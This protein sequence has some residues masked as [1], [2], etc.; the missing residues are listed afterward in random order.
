[1][2]RRFV[3]A[4][5]ARLRPALATVSVVLAAAGLLLPA[6][7]V[8]AASADPSGPGTGALAECGTPRLAPALRPARG[9]VRGLSPRQRD[10]AA[11]TLR[12]AADAGLPARGQAIVLMTRSSA[13]RVDALRLGRTKVPSVA[14]QARALRR[15]DG[16]ETLPP[17][18]VAHRLLGTPDPYAFEGQ[19][20][21]TLTTLSKA[22]GRPVAGVQAAIEPGARA[23]RQC[24]PKR[25][26]SY[27]V[28]V[29]SGYDL[30][31]ML[32]PAQPAGSGQGG[33]G[34]AGSGQGG[35]GRGSSAKKRSTKDANPRGSDAGEGAEQ[36]SLLL[37]A[38]CGVPVRAVSAGRV[39]IDRS[40]RTSGP[41][42]ITVEQGE[43]RS[44]YRHVTQPLVRYGQ[45]V[46]AGEQ[47]ATV[48]DLGYID[49][50]ALGFGLRIGKAM[51]RDHE[52][53]RWLAPAEAKDKGP[54][55]PSKTRKSKDRE[56]GD[57]GAT[58]SFRITTFNVLGAHLTGRGGDRPRYGAGSA[59][60]AAAMGRLNNSGSSIAV[61][62]EF[63][64]PQAAVVSAAPGWQLHRATGNSRFRS[65]NYSGN[66][67][68]WRTDTW[69]LVETSEFTVPWK[70]RLHM[71]V[72]YLRHVQTGA[73]VAVIGV[74]NPASTK[75]QGDQSR[76]RGV[77]RAVEKQAVAQILSQSEMPV[78]L[79]GDMN[80]RGKAIC[81]FAGAGL[82]TWKSGGGRCGSW[83]YGGV[84]HVFAAGDV[85][86]TGLTVDRSTLGRVSDH[87]MVTA[88]V[89]IN[90]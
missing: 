32:T 77:A 6:P 84:D 8:P 1:M 82:A 87:P 45:R 19:W 80:E 66:A 83:G 42:S 59:R 86:Y 38:P 68:A 70:V 52:V 49:R 73:M 17:E 57:T 5:A 85:A 64:S 89:T 30:L 79:G 7:A 36:P 26:R 29:G 22:T 67:V 63:E 21:R 71:P 76:A 2:T 58:T 27:P 62:Q 3:L 55:T 33:S 23:G 14:R 88:S 47:L 10:L 43:L 74:H 54:V 15:L 11:T 51:L 50:C 24:A 46:E 20:S 16:W 25:G 53:A 35:S 37:G 75:R 18:L 65:G 34:Q 81:D 60:M 56:N 90:P 72:V 69:T 31:R 9:K 28:P 61:F 13:G 44:T 41:W 12:R 39:S 78:L 40:D 4:P 48:G